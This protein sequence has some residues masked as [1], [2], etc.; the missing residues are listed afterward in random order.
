MEDYLIECPSA[1]F[2]ALARVICDLFPEQT[3][4][5]ES[6]DE[7]GRFL[8]VQWV[9]MRFG[10]TPKRMTFD[11]RIAPAAFAR[12]LALKPMQRARSHAVLH[13]YVEATLGSLEE[14][15]AAGEAVP[16]DEVLMLDE[17]FA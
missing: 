12:Y 15:H 13:A 10:S 9:A 16:R 1:E 5:V 17:E 3:R 11:V 4:F 14:R 6:S 8:S 2:D 7:R